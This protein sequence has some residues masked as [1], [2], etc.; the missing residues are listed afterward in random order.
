MT[1]RRLLIA[2]AVPL[3][4]ILLTLASILASAALIRNASKGRLHINVRDIEHRRVGLVLGCSKLLDDGR[5]N[6]FF[7]NRIAAA[8]QLYQAG[9]LEVFIVSGDNG[10]GDYDEATDMMHA[11]E[12]AGVP[13]SRIY[14]DYAGFRTNDSIIRAKKIFG[15]D[16]ITII[17]QRFHNERAIYI[18]THQGVDAIGFNAPDVP[19]SLRTEIREHFSRVKTVLDVFL[20]TAPRYLGPPVEVQ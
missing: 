14:R 4:G 1:R 17:S 18:A 19:G 9:K 5:G 20:G 8:C 11:L 13:G 10:R 2:A 15:Q 12:E 3:F 16:R 6:P 7:T